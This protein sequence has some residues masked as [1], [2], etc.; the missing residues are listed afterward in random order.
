MNKAKYIAVEGPIGVG[1]TTLAK[2]LAEDF[3]GELI[4][5]HVTHNPFL[6][7]F[8][9]NQKEAALSTQLYFF[10]HR[11]KLLKQLHQKDLFKETTVTDF[12]LEKDRIFAETTL[13]TLELDL[14]LEIADQITI[15]LVIPDL[16]IYLQAPVDILKKRI[17]KRGRANE[18]S[19]SNAYLQQLIDGYTRFFHYYDQAPLLIV[20]ATEID[21][22]SV[23]A[24]Y[25]E[26]LKQ[27]ENTKSGRHYFNPLPHPNTN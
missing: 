25:Q 22:V 13:N 7:K 14:Y 3:K 1:K 4:L 23:E 8:Y 20:N 9:D 26:L 5:E 2:R 11:V 12:L 19:I 27:V 21:I 15:D 18:K 16:V 6:D 17:A 24:D 10:L